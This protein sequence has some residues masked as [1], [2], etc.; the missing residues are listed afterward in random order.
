MAE[1]NPTHL[2]ACIDRMDILQLF[3]R[4][5]HIVD[6]CEFEKLP[7]VFTD[8]AVLD[9]RSLGEA[10]AGKNTLMH[11][12]QEFVEFLSHSMQFMGPGLTHFMA[13]HLIDVTGDEAHIVSHNHVL[14][15]PQGGRYT[16]H[17]RRTPVGWRIDHFIFE[18]RLYH[19]MAAKMGYST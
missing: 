13:N 8:D 6:D 14:N 16:S 9:Y 1:I 4:Y 5:C 18:N 2:Q 3:A 19:A 12:V 17:A 7:E 11:G 10:V 15:F